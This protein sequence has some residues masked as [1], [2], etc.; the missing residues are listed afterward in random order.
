MTP[1]ERKAAAFDTTIRNRVEKRIRALRA[2]LKHPA[3]AG[4]MLT[5]EE[6]ED[7]VLAFDEG[8]RYRLPGAPLV[9]PGPVR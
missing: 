7:I 4:V 8:W 5:R 6:I 1:E 9:E 3:F 2:Y